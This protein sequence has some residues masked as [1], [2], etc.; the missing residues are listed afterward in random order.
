[1]FTHLNSTLHPSTTFLEDRFTVRQNKSGKP[2]FINQQ[3]HVHCKLVQFTPSALPPGQAPRRGSA[4]DVETLVVLQVPQVG[5]TLPTL[6]AHELFLPG[7]DLLVGLQAVALVEAAS[8]RVAA[9]RLLPRVDA[10]VSVQVARVA[11]TFPT[12]VAAERFLSRVHH[13]QRGSL[14]EK[15]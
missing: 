9:E 8:T 15:L 1:M 4:S 7:V 10:L 12:R 14:K 11:E 3:N 13:L 2:N 6:V 5:E